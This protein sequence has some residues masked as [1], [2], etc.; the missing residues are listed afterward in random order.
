MLI[1]SLML[2][3]MS[4]MVSLPGE[5]AEPVAVDQ[6][7]QLA[8]PPAG[9]EGVP[10]IGLTSETGG[11]ST[12]APAPE[13]LIYC[14][15]LEATTS[16]DW[17]IGV[18]RVFEP[19]DPTPKL[20]AIIFRDASDTPPVDRIEETY[21]VTWETGRRRFQRE[22]EHRIRDDRGRFRLVIK[23]LSLVG[24]ITATVGRDQ[25]VRGRV[26]CSN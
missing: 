10:P 9:M 18:A 15:I 1:K 19:N 25:K 2:V 6:L 14:L 17:K 12:K 4:S 20:Q 11:P 23:E 21:A 8:G 7:Q 3:A 5:A 13:V 16:T 26:T 22:T 24:T